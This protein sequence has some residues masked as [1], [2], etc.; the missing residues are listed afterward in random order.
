M[1]LPFWLS[2]T[3]DLLG[4]TYPLYRFLIIVAGLA[5]APR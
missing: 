3:I 5:A 4:V 1:G 2:G